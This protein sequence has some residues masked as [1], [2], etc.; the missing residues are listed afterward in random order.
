MVDRIIVPHQFIR[1]RGANADKVNENF[2]VLAAGVNDTIDLANSFDGRIQANTNEISELNNE[3]S[4]LALKD[5]SNV[6]ENV[7]VDIWKDIISDDMDIIIDYYPK[8]ADLATWNGSYQWE[9]YRSGKIKAEGITTYHSNGQ[10]GFENF[11]IPFTK[12]PKFTAVLEVYYG[13]ISEVQLAIGRSVA[14]EDGVLLNGFYW[15]LFRRSG[16]GTD[17]GYIHWKATGF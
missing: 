12:K 7:S 10:S 14:N 4:Q 16:S 17:G 2:D 3:I 15:H 11:P 5:F 13:Q 6:D 8:P 1:G 9:K